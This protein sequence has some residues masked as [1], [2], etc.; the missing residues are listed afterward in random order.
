MSILFNLVMFLYRVNA[1]DGVLLSKNAFNQVQ[2]QSN[3][4]REKTFSKMKQ[5]LESLQQLKSTLLE[6]R[7]NTDTIVSIEKSQ[8]KKWVKDV[9]LSEEQDAL[10]QEKAT[11]LLDDIVPLLFQYWFKVI[12]SYLKHV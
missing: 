5:F 1:N 3:S 2:V 9:Y 4:K 10:F 6:Y 12:H 7:E 11:D 8:I